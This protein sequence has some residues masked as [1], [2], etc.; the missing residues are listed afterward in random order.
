VATVGLILG[1]AYFLWTLQRMFFG[2]FNVKQEIKATQLTDLTDRE[3]SMLLSLSILTILFGIFPQVLLDYI[4][5]FA[6]HFTEA[7]LNT[8]NL[9]K[10]L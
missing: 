2:P 8:A 7:I 4:N 1:A 5:P 3:R 6:Q 9:I 10:N